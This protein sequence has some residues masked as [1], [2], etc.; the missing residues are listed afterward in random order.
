MQCEP[1]QE[2]L[3]GAYSA[4]GCLYEKMKKIAQLFLKSP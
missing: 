3:A 2:L 1:L 4:R